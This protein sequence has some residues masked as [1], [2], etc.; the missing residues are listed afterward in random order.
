MPSLTVLTEYSM[1]TIQKH[2]ILEIFH[3]S[4][5]YLATHLQS[6][7]KSLQI[8]YFCEV[9][10][11]STSKINADTT[12]QYEDTCIQLLICKLTLDLLVLTSLVMISFVRS[13]S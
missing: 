12:Q 2:V 8:R 6:R 1:C 9:V 11:C 10:A 13:F 3:V 7:W 5:K 4:G